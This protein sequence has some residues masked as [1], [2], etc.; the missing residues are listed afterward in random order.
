MSRRGKR[1]APESAAP[2]P[3]IQ[4]DPNDEFSRGQQQLQELF[5]ASRRYRKTVSHRRALKGHNAAGTEAVHKLTTN[6]VVGSKVVRQQSGFQQNYLKEAARSLQQVTIA[7]LTEA[8]TNRTDLYSEFQIKKRSRR[9]LL[10]DAQKFGT[11]MSPF[12]HRLPM[13]EFRCVIALRP[14]SRPR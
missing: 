13:L 10:I 3:E 4:G 11:M 7:A 8:L 14:P 12:F 9:E 5:E 6:L 2:A 1:S